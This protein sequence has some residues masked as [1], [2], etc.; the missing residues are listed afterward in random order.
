[1][2]PI[3]DKINS[4]KVQTLSSSEG[5]FTFD[6]MF[7]L[8]VVYQDDKIS[9]R[10]FH[11]LMTDLQNLDIITDLVESSG[12][13]STVNGLERVSQLQDAMDEIG[14]KAGRIRDLARELY[15]L[16]RLFTI[17]RAPSS[18]GIKRLKDYLTIGL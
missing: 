12:I 4:W 13:P 6:K 3:V 14:F 10:S 15:K 2:L 11:T 16:E 17:R 8:H 18:K 5:I 7:S 9:Q 1:M